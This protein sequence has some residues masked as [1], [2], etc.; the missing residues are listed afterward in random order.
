LLVIKAALFF[1]SALISLTTS[2]MADRDQSMTTSAALE[3]MPGNG[4]LAKLRS[5]VARM[6]GHKQATSP[7]IAK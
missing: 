5:D 3:T 4:E 7:N 6:L 1:E 2:R